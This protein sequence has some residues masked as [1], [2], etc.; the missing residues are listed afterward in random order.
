MHQIHILQTTITMDLTS[1]DLNGINFPSGFQQN[2]KP[3]KSSSR[4][5]WYRQIPKPSVKLFPCKSLRLIHYAEE[6]WFFRSEKY[7]RPQTFL[8]LQISVRSSLAAQ[9]APE[10]KQSD[11]WNAVNESDSMYY[12]K[13]T[14]HNQ[15]IW[16]EPRE[17]TLCG[18]LFG[19][20]MNAPP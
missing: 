19:L 8:T 4:V 14:S 18:V 5:I 6:I 16:Q 2:H 13:Q 7:R 9:R 17:N 20:L 12:S 15:I 3:I 10:F 11:L 1:S